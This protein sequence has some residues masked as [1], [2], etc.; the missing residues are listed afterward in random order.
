MVTTLRR[1]KHCVAL[2]AAL[3][4]VQATAHAQHSQ[5]SPAPLSTPDRPGV[6]GMLVFGTGRVYASHLP[7]FH[8]PHDYQVLLEIILSDSARAAYT[9]S[10]RKF[11][12]EQVYTL[13]PE[14]FVLPAMLQQPRPFKATLY[15]GHFE[16]GGTPIAGGVTVRIAKVLYA[17]Q[18]QANPDPETKAEY[19]LVGNEQEQFLVHR[20][21]ARPNFDQVLRVSLPDA[22]TRKQL[23]Q[24]GS[25]VLT[26]PRLAASAEP[27][28]TPATI[29]GEVAGRKA[30]LRA[31]G[32]LYLEH[33]DLK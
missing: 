21:G 17:K 30:A 27:I 14:K 12:D 23:A 26:Q 5:H 29:T 4:F 8:S 1:V 22:R 3:L 28:T 13:E 15:R 19:V 11:P 33:E 24:Q 6:H 9:T 18:L 31:S 10:R 7:M 25:L 16:R 20:I 2:A 32:S